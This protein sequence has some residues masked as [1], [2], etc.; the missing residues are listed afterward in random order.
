MAAKTTSGSGFRLGRFSQQLQKKFQGHFFEIFGVK[1]EKFKEF[2]WSYKNFPLAIFWYFVAVVPIYHCAKIHS[3]SLSNKLSREMRVFFDLADF[4]LIFR[5][6]ERIDVCP[7]VSR[8]LNKLRGPF[9]INLDNFFPSILIAK[10]I[11]PGVKVRGLQRPRNAV[12]AQ[13]FN[14]FYFFA[15]PLCPSG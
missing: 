9:F 14:F 13:D 12:R 15:R 2:F 11:P 7:F 8:K 3:L 10:N 4:W 1:V 5:F 6:F